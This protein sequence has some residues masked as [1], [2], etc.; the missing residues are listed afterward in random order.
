MTQLSSYSMEDNNRTAAH[1]TLMLVLQE[2]FLLRWS[3]SRF[4]PKT[5]SVLPAQTTQRCLPREGEEE[6][7]SGAVLGLPLSTEIKE[8]DMPKNNG[9]NNGI[10]HRIHYKFLVYHCHAS[11]CG[12]PANNTSSH[13]HQAEVST[14][15]PSSSRTHCSP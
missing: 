2:R 9:I 15:W 8:T 1:P 13:G 5:T 3:K 12:Q 14:P 6:R 7:V 11:N 10:T 4:L